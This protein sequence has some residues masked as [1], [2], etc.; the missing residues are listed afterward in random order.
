VRRHIQDNYGLAGTD[1]TLH[2]YWPE[3]FLVI[4]SNPVDLR[5]VLEAPPLPQAEMV[6]RFRRWNRL[7][8]ADGDSMR[9]RV[10][11]EIR[12]FPSHAW[13]ATTAQIILGD[14]CTAP[15]PTPTTTAN[16]D[17]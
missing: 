15:E 13:S 17:F 9:Y 11:L 8:T 5:R 7:A 10:L 3:D 2:R 16:A 4:F 1:F 14:A 12:G 6:L